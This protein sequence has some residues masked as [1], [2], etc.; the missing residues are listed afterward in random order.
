MVQRINNGDIHVGSIW[1]TDKAY[2]CLD[3][4]FNKKIWR[5][6]GTENPHVAVP[7]SL[8]LKKLIVWAA[9]F[10][11]R[12]IAPFFR[13]EMITSPCY[14]DILLEFLVVKNALKD[15]ANILWFM[16]DGV[17][18]HRTADVFNFPNEHFDDRMIA[19]DY[20]TH[21]GRGVN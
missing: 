11:K 2:F 8:H 20:P 1:F 18:P 5:M 14:L 7:L 12:R 3:G 21:T 4:V 9:I 13:S 16:Q 17:W 15:T 10:F 6:W 19:L